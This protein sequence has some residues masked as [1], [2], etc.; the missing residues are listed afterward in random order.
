MQTSGNDY[1]NHRWYVMGKASDHV[2][3]AGKIAELGPG[4]KHHLIQC[5][6]KL[7]VDLCLIFFRED[8]ELGHMMRGA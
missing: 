4:D 8:V 5:H 1:P 2:W 6:L 3:Q 7:Q